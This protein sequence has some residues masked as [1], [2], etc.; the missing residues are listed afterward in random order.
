M[1]DSRQPSPI[2]K[3]PIHCMVVTVSCSHAMARVRTA[4]SSSWPKMFCCRGPRY[5]STKHITTF[6]TV[7]RMAPAKNTTFVW[8]VVSGNALKGAKPSLISIA[9]AVMAKDQMAVQAHK[10]YG[11]MSTCMR[12]WLQ[13]VFRLRHKHAPR[14]R[15][16]ANNENAN[17]PLTHSIAPATTAMIDIVFEV[18]VL[19]Y[20]QTPTTYVVAGVHAPKIDTNAAVPKTRAV[21]FRASDA[22]LATE[23]S[24]VLF[25]PSLLG[26][27]MHEA[28]TAVTNMWNAV[29]A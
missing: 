21:L 18:V 12:S 7:A 26:R 2:S 11:L 25:P 29:V 14:V 6:R 20:L 22:A 27:S 19:P 28:T 9:T 17:S 24:N 16:V 8:R 3:T 15:T 13:T 4:T 10:R 5:F 23:M 1:W